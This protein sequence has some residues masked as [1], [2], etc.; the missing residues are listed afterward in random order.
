MTGA[1]TAASTLGLPDLGLATL[2]DMLHNAT[3]LASLDRTV[4]LVADADTGYGGPLMVARTVR[5]YIQAGVAGLHL[6][7]QVVQKRCG[8]LLGKEVVG[9]EEFYARIR[10][11]VMAR[12]EMREEVGGDIVLIAR[13]DALQGMGM[14]EALERLKRCVEIGV[15]V[16]FLEG[17]RSVEECKT[18]CEEMAPTPVLFNSVPGG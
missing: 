16:V 8:H 12:Q 3:M 2:N 17:L 15:D 11:A 1:G 7:D 9:R 5:S 14:D 13:T 6:E 10:A 18:V 4:P